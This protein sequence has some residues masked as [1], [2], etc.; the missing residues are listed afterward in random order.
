MPRHFALPGRRSLR[1]GSAAGKILPVRAM[2]FVNFGLR[3]AGLAVLLCVSTP[4]HADSW[5]NP[6]VRE[7]FSAKLVCLC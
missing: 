7:V 4:A 3:A 2:N 6:V 5:A 1:V